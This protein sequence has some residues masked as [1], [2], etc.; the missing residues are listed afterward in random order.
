MGEIKVRYVIKKLSTGKIETSIVSLLDIERGSIPIKYFMPS[1]Y[2]ILGRNLYIGFKDKN[3]KEIYEG[4]LIRMIQSKNIYQMVI[5]DEGE[6]YFEGKVIS[7]N[8]CGEI[9]DNENLPLADWSEDI[10]IIGDIYENP[11]LLKGDNS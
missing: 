7:D 8:S 3:G 5:G 10:E 4:D 6:R 9:W 2:K 1:I 11:E